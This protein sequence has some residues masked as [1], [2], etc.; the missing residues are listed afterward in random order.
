MAITKFN[1]VEGLT[2]G[3]LVQIPVIDNTANVSANNLNVQGDSNLGNLATANYFTGNGRLLS[4]ITLANTIADV[5]ITSPTN[6]QTLIYNGLVWVNTNTGAVSAGQGVSFWLSTPIINAINANNAIQVDSL[7]STPNTSAQTYAN[8]TVNGTAAIA[9]FVSPP[10]NRTSWDAGNWDFSLWANISATGGTNTLNAGIH[11]ILP[12]AGTV[13]TTGTGTTRTATASTG[14]PFANV[15]AGSDVI[16]SSYIQTPQGLY[17]VTAKTSDTVVSINVPT[18]Y[19][20]ETTVTASVWIPLFN[21]GSADMS[22]TSL[23]EYNFTTTE[24]AWPVTTNSS[25]GLLLAATTSSSKSVY[26]TINGTNQ[27]SHFTTPLATLHDQLAGLQ[28]GQVD[29]YYHLTYN[30]Y[31]GTGTGNFV[32]QSNAN[33]IN[34]NIDSATGLSLTL[35]GNLVSGNANLG[36]LAVANYVTGTLTTGNQPNITSLGTLSGLTSNGIVNF[37]TASNVSLGNVS[38]LKILGGSAGYVLKTDGTGNLSWGIDTTAAAGNNTYVQFNDGGSLG[39]NANFT[40]DKS[41]SLLTVTGNVNAL[42]ADLGNLVAAN[43]FSG[44]GSLLSSITGGNVTGQVGNALV[45][46]T[47]YTN[48]QPNITSLGTLTSLSVSGNASFTGA[49]TYFSNI[50]NVKI[51]G[52]SNGYVLKTDGAGNLSW[53]IDVTDYSNTN[54]AAYLPTYTG[55]FTAGNANIS[56]NIISGNASLGNLAT[57][58][59][60]SGDGSLLTNITGGNVTGQVGNALVAGTVYTNAQPN[61]TSL[62]TLTS[63]SVTGNISAGNAN[64]GNLVIANY[65]SGDGSLLSNLNTANIGTVANANYAAFAGNVTI[66]AQPNITSLGTLSTLSVAGNITS[67][68]AS[69]GNLATANY[70]SGDG[71]LLTSLTGGNVTGQVANALIAGTVYTNAQPNITSVG[72]L[73]SLTVSGNITSGNANLGNLVVANYFSGNGSLLSSITGANVTGQVG[74]ALI[75]GTVY[76]NAQP[77]ITSVGTLSTLSVSGNI[78]SGNASLG[79]LAVAN[80]FNGDGSLLSSLTG[81]NVTGQVANALIAGTV[82]TNA[83]PNITSVGTLTSLNITGNVSSG[84]ANL[85]NL[86]LANYFSGDGSLLSNLNVANIVTVANANYAAFAGNVTLASQPNI[87]SVGNLS[88]LTVSGNT[89]IAGNLTVSGT[90][91][92]ANVTTLNVKD[93]IIELG[94]T[95]NND[96]LSS[97]DGKDR[98]TLLHY[99]TTTPI[100]AFMGWD[101][102]NGEFGF[103]SNVTATNEVITWNSY[104]NIRAGYIIA[105]GSLLTSITGGNVTGQ[106]GNALIAGTVY[107]NAQPNITSLGTLSSLNVTGNISSGNASLG[108]LITANYFS[109]DGSLLTNITGSNVTGQVGNALIAGTVYTNAQPNITSLGNLASLNVVG[110]VTSNNASLGNLV[111]ANYFSGNGSLLSSLNGSNVTGQVGNALIAGTVYTNAQPNITSLGTLSSLSVTGNLTSGNANLGNLVIANYFS[112]DGSLLSNLNTANIGTVA[113]AN[114]AAFAGNVTLAAQPNITSLGTLVNLSVTGNITSGNATLGNLATANF[115]SGNGSLLSSITGGNVTGQVGNALIAGTVYTN[116]QPNITSLGTLSTLSVTGN[117]SSGNANLG[118]LTTSNFFSGNG[119]LLTSIT[120]A[121]VT[122]QVANALIAGTVYTNAQPNITSLG[123]LS[124][125]SVTGNVSSGNANLGNLVTANFLSGN[126]SLLTSITGANVTGQVGNALVSGTV[127]TNAQ[128]NITSVGTLTSL[129][130]TGNISSGNANLG[131]LVVANYFSGDGGLL[132]NINPSNIGTVANANYAAFAGNVTLA[133]Q[134]NITSVGNLSSLTVSGNTTIA[135]NLTVTGNTV[136]ANVT[137]LNVKDPIIELGGTGNNDPLTSND[138]KDR[139][140]L[141]HYYTT[142]PIDAFMGW[143]NSNGEFGFGSNV[144]ATNEVITWNS[145][146]NIRANYFIGNGALLTGMYSNTNVAA[147]LPTYTGNVAANYF[148]GNGSALTSLT[149]GNVTGQV[150]NALIAGTVYTAAQPNITSVGTLSSLTVSGLITATG[151]GIKVANIYD[152]TT[153]LTIETRYGNIAGDAGVYGNLTVGTSGTG[154]ITAYN[155]NL[156]NLVIGNFLQG[157]LT[158]GAQ[159]N[160][161]SVGTLGNLSVTANASAGNI[162]TN[163]LLY[164]NGTPWSFGDVYSNANVANYLPTYTGNFTAGNI[165]VTGSVIG[166]AITANYVMVTERTTGNYYPTFVSSNSSGNYALG[167]N[168]DISYDAGNSTLYISK[169][170]SG[171]GNGGTISGANLVSANFFQGDGGLLSNIAAGNAANANYSNFAGTVITAAQPNI[172]SLGTLS[173]LSVTGNASAGNILTDSLLYANGVAWSFGTTYSNANVANYLPTYTGNL[174]AGNFTLNSL[175]TGQIAISSSGLIVGGPDLIWDFANSALTI[176]NLKANGVISTTSNVTASN[177]NLGNLVTANYFTGNASLLSSIT[178]SN[179]TGQVGNALLAG[180]VYTNAQPNITSLGTLSNL[181]VTANVSAGN[182]LT[183]NLLYANGVAWNFGS[184]Y[185]N[186]NVAEYLP[187]YTGNFTAGNANI[188]GS[189]V[190]NNGTLT[191]GLIMGSGSGGN[192]VGANVISANL[193]TGTLTTGA[194]PNIT[195]LGNLSNLTSN[196]VIDF[197]NSSNVTLGN[198]SNLHIAGG[199]LG[200]VLKT[201]GAGNLSWGIDSAA[202]GG[203]NTEVQFNDNN[204]LAGSANFTFNKTTNTLSVTNI[205]GNGAGITYITGS[206]VNGQVG[207]ALV[208]GTVYT[209]AQPN[210][211]SLGTLSSLSVTANVSAGNIKSDNLLYAN[212][213]PY[214]FTTNAAGSNTQIQFND[215]NAFAG[216]A[217]LTFNKATNTLTAYNFVTT[218]ANVNGIANLG[219]VSNVKI[220]GGST[221]YV[222]STDGLGNLSWQVGAGGGAGFVNI[223]KDNFVGNGVQTNFS[224]STVPSAEAALQVNI[225]GLIQQDWV[226]S[227]SGSTLIF[228]D[229]PANNANIEV[230]IYGAITISGANTQVLFIDG[231]NVNSNSNFTFN[232]T[233]ST[234]SV[235]NLSVTGNVLSGNLSA[236][237]GLLTLGSGTIEVSGANAGIFTVGIGNTNIGLAGNVTLGSASGNVTVQGNLSVANTA[238]ITNLKVNDFYSNRTPIVVTTGTVVDSFSTTKYRSAKYTMRVNSDD[239]YQAVEVLLIHNGT[240]S[241]VTIYGSLSTIGSDIITLSTDINSGNVRMLATTSSPNTTVNLLGT[242]VSD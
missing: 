147:Y 230:T 17:R 83:Q 32:R 166:N 116:A 104:G 65:F 209:N 75:A 73:S 63:L 39:G 125:L 1:V 74:N 50:A 176:T 107:T 111:T 120:G 29:E 234:L 6:G 49:N 109:G 48:A 77:N 123:T 5:S 183:N 238:T 11:Q 93:P 208:A 28:G 226:Y 101:N 207:N 141:L 220:T 121:N 38:N 13:T 242:Y 12:N 100:D 23:F 88:S 91:V 87:T 24:P 240:N 89:T 190:A 67:G 56:G 40:F 211:T 161:T 173:N 155:A 70:F 156:G 212:G 189:I 203:S 153:T 66:A 181:S 115:F 122:G 223:N 229:P 42:N 197:N 198:V 113:N 202:A 131:N 169:L 9:G 135:G 219:S 20:N 232:K 168:A 19:T 215:G 239:G 21:I 99:Y 22:T 150:A 90:T 222:L 146:G 97:N 106:V 18:T 112:G 163:N 81:S 4:G 128:P 140:T 145:Y 76:T 119:S 162:L 43:F 178:G 129:T 10:L 71:S 144:T 96:P 221:G 157:T 92:Y 7:S 210:I 158:T 139:G 98:G 110:N 213:T 57:A 194:Q 72:N 102:S 82:Y 36:N 164:A 174:Q 59:Y 133:A 118:N 228:S 95:G 137:T 191:G 8:V 14:T 55:N 233:T 52:G 236:T 84:N 3:G 186:A 94:G 60:F 177:A 117:I 217:N 54:V 151:T 218:N 227:L 51:P 180:T 114:Y 182:V 35:T 103:G 206:N 187:T 25:M 195:S 45:A 16:L 171:S 179:V 159:P 143:D 86:V 148:I 34:P 193:L 105:D 26:V 214:V 79:N 46:G 175:G 196:G 224:L 58:N 27:A 160:I 41:T 132:S 80:Y 241:F 85:G 44:N 231:S 62:G 154:N 149:G 237:S 199:S 205:I 142:A 188:S 108:N 225:D 53:G 33:L 235:S 30:E 47:V 184:T 201:D 172:T 192:I 127:Y 64:L 124:T 126:G 216:S 185:S 165:S 69:L 134:P 170:S 200:Y 15:V 167:A 2:V 136:Y 204:S 152:S 130:V 61:I 68:N 37:T 78:T 138:G 31:A